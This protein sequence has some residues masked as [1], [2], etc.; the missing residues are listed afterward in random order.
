MPSTITKIGSLT[1]FAVPQIPFLYGEITDPTSYHC[2]ELDGLTGRDRIESAAELLSEV[3]NFEASFYTVEETGMGWGTTTY[4]IETKHAE[5]FFKYCYDQKY[6]LRDL[7][8]GIVYEEGLVSLPIEE[9][10]AWDTPDHEEISEEMIELLEAEF[11]KSPESF[12]IMANG[13]IRYGYSL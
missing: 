10:F 6:T 7:N 2:K 9:F 8:K 13:T 12:R 5:D 3:E 1:V 11:K 4:K